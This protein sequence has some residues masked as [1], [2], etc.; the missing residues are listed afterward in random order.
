[1]KSSISAGRK[2]PGSSALTGGS[3][4]SLI[5]PAL[6]EL[7]RSAL[8]GGRVGTD[9][10]EE[11][12]P[13]GTKKHKRAAAK[14]ATDSMSESMGEAK[15]RLNERG[16]KLRQI[17]EKAFAVKEGAS[18]FRDMARQLNKGTK[19]KSTSKSISSKSKSST[20]SPGGSSG[21]GGGVVGLLSSFFG[22]GSASSSSSKSKAD[23]G[24][25]KAAAKK[26]TTSEGAVIKSKAAG[27][28]NT[29]L[30]KKSSGKASVSSGGTV[31]KKPSP[32]TVGPVG[33]TS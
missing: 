4:L 19:K 6:L 23:V 31:G 33:S 10:V 17:D 20:V 16:E 8:F 29:E 30:G 11:G 18:D 5:D 22:L 32:A 7:N 2:P 14:V 3:G 13:T 24:S 28:T 9:I 27:S 15:S 21:G 1:M 12:G 25:A 26:P